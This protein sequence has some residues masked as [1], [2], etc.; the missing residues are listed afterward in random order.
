MNVTVSTTV[1]DRHHH[2]LGPIEY[3]C[4]AESLECCN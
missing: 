4:E 1:E 3:E 2:V